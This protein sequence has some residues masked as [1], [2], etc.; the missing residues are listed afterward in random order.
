[1]PPSSPLAA[2]ILGVFAF[3]F[4][5]AV[6]SFV[7]V[8]VHRLPDG[9]V[10]ALSGRSRCPRCGSPIQWFDNVPVVSWLVLGMRCRR[11]RGPISIRYPAV[12][13]LTG[14]LFL[15]AWWSSAQQSVDSGRGFPA[16]LIVTWV[17][18]SVL[19]ALSLIDLRL[20]IL[21]DELTIPTMVAGP[22]VAAFLPGRWLETWTGERLRPFVPSDSLCAVAVSLIGMAVGAGVL[23]AVRSLGTRAF[24]ATRE[25]PVES[26][27]G[28]SD[29]LDAFVA[30]QRPR[31]GKPTVRGWIEGGLVRIRRAGEAQ[32]LLTVDPTQRVR[33]GDVVLV[34]FEREAMGFGDVKL[35]GAIGAFV[36]PEGSLLVLALASLAGAVIGSLN[37]VRYFAIL[38]RRASRRGRSSS[39]GLW[40]IARAAGGTVPFGPYLAGGAAAL[41]IAREPLVAFLHDTWIHLT[42]SPR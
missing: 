37:I 29:R 16:T 6:G 36:G 19:L 25:F 20:R 15:A 40:R 34:R 7:N 1:M 4:G 27:E 17:L 42:I 5:L 41:L 10:R 8:V 12:E 32:G 22:I 13:L 28:V 31:H 30:H 38:L 35:Q 14:L 23:A 39:A 3:F 2:P 26:L 21:P 11:C 18:L 24:S 33:P 9:G